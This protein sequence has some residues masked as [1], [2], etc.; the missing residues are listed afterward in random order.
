[1][2]PVSFVGGQSLRR[3]PQV[4]PSVSQTVPRSPMRHRDRYP[5]SAPGDFYVEDGC[6]TLCGVP[7]VTAPELFGGFD[8]EGGIAE[9]AEQCWVKRQPHSPRELSAM[10]ETM[11]RQELG[12]IRY[13][14]SDPA[15]VA[16]IHEVGEGGQID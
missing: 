9:G 10:I 12:C 7:A 16:R 15:I 6:C 3:A 8:P 2:W 13:S 1:M 11:A 5:L 4:K 14:G